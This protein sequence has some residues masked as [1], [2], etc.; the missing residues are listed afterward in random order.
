MA[1]PFNTSNNNIN[2]MNNMYKQLMNSNNPMKVFENITIQN[3]QFRPILE[4]LKAN[5]PQ[6]VFISLCNQRGIDPNMFIK[7]IIR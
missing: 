4:M 6:Q 7:N 2:N 3:P 5:N 1:N